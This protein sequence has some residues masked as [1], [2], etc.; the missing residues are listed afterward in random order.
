VLVLF[1]GAPRAGLVVGLRGSAALRPRGLTHSARTGRAATP[2]S[3]SV[4]T[5]PR[6]V[7]LHSHIQRPEPSQILRKAAFLHVQQIE[8]VT[9]RRNG[10]GA[11]LVSE[12]EAR[13]TS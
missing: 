12:E 6:M 9:L 11:E 8:D 2:S 10:W 3:N 7:V 4:R 1:R 13:R 5:A